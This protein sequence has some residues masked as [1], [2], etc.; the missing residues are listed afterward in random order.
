VDTY[1]IG[2][3]DPDFLRVESFQK[4]DRAGSPMSVAK[5]RGELLSSFFSSPSSPRLDSSRPVQRRD[6]A[7]TSEEKRGRVIL[8]YC[9]RGFTR[10]SRGYAVRNGSKRVKIASVRPKV[11]LVT[12]L[13]RGCTLY[14]QV[15]DMLI[16]RH[17][18][19]GTARS[20]ARG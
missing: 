12:L 19:T 3:T 15:R 11:T 5:S 8:Y 9:A 18:K 1:S 2:S 17:S 13:P 16:S 20:L 14:C 4:P 10:S 7:D 6:R